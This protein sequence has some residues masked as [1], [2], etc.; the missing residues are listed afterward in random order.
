VHV[1]RFSHALHIGRRFSEFLDISNTLLN[2]G[3]GILLLQL[4]L[5][6]FPML[7]L[8]VVGLIERALL[9]LVIFLDPLSFIGHLKN[10]LQL[11]NAP[12]RQTMYLL[13]ADTVDSA[14]HDRFWSEI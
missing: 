6:A 4:I 10:N 14:H 12:P 1:F 7:I 11:H 3:F 13:L 5:L 8:W 9:R 2:L